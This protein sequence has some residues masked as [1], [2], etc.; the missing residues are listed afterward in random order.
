[1]KSEE[2]F[3]EAKKYIPGGVNSP[4]R[5]FRSVDMDPVFITEGRG[6]TVIDVDGNEYIDFVSSWGPLILG[7]ANPAII[8]KVENILEKGTSFG[9]PTELEVEMA[10]RVVECV[11][12]IEKVRMV[13]SGTEAVMSA[14]RLA[15]GFTGKDKIIKFEG[16][17]HGHSDAM[18]AKAGSGVTTLG[19][20]DSP[21]VTKA[22]TEDTIN[23]A[24]ND[25]EAL[26]QAVEKYKDEIACLIVEPVAGNMG[27]VPPKPGFLEFLREITKAN[28]IVLIFDEVITGFR[29]SLGGAQQYYNVTPD[30]TTLGKIIGGGFPVGAFGGRA[31]IMD[32]VAPSGPVYQA[33]TLSG[34]P[35]A[36]AAGLAMIDELSNEKLYQELDEKGAYLEA[37]LKEAA[38]Q[39]GVSAFFTRV[40]SMLS[41]FFTNQEVFDYNSAKT[42]DTDFFAAYF[43]KML[44]QGIYLAPSQFE[45]TFISA[46]HSQQELD[47]A[48]AA[49]KIALQG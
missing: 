49:A 33:G 8:K 18:L 30:L 43:K 31:D 10:K 9:A 24:Y 22:A 17:Y 25:T 19:L 28:S 41:M 21:G 36:M 40:G 16:C 20:P 13:S 14:I 47:Q 12:S 37:G 35:V 45:A 38:S 27:V 44:G 3:K 39:A 34:N 48:I 29:L 32:M 23:I 4:V 11:P 15:R 7:H 1:M 46:A 42:S 26:G 6:S 2:L 5:A